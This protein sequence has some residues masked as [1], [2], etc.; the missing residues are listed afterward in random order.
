[1]KN[2]D[3]VTRNFK[4]FTLTWQLGSIIRRF[5]GFLMRFFSGFATPGIPA[6]IS[7]NSPFDIDESSWN[8]F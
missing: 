5:L 3:T 2:D 7:R 4:V 1:M 8:Y 6:T